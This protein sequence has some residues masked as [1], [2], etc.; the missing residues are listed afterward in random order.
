MSLL[1]NNRGLPPTVSWKQFLPKSPTKRR[2]KRGHRKLFIAPAL[3]QKSRGSCYVECGN[4]K[5]VAAVYGPRE[6]LKSDVNVM[7]G[8]LSCQFVISPFATV[9]GEQATT[10]GA[11]DERETQKL[12][13]DY[14]SF[15][16]ECFCSVVDRTKFP[17]STLDLTVLVLENDGGVLAQS[18]TA[19]SCAITNAGIEMH[20]LLIGVNSAVLTKDWTNDDSQSDAEE[21][22][23]YSIDP[24]FDDETID[25]DNEPDQSTADD[26]RTLSVVTI[27][28]LPNVNQI[29]TLNHLG[30][31][32][33]AEVLSTA[34]KKCIESC[35]Q[36]YA[37]VQTFLKQDAQNEDI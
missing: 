28:Y 35:P 21:T 33:S 12:C 7:E 32:P 5:V 9:P 6:N 37:A 16:E 23:E 4:T 1:L 26:Q 3:I 2:E 13:A 11:A 29:A 19:L 8:K 24:C 30:Q 18:L 14:E 22:C 25:Y 27:G 20:D 10:A 31:C 34:V 36:V 15:V 17:K